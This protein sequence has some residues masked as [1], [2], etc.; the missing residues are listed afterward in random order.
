MRYFLAPIMWL[1][2]GLFQGLG[3]FGRWALRGFGRLLGR[4]IPWVALA[5]GGLW[6]AQNQ[7]HL[8]AQLVQI[9]IVITGLI[10]MIREFRKGKKKK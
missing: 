3:E 7:P 2:Q 8:F 5:I 9:G 10:I 4:L 1:L 6:L